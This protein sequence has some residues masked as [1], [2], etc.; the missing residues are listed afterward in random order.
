[1]TRAAR[2]WSIAAAFAALTAICALT[3]DEPIARALGV[4]EPSPLW[5]RGIAALEYAAG[6]EPW[7]WATLVVLGVGAAACLVRPAWRGALP[8]WIYVAG[9]GLLAAI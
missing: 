4:Y 8:A 5:N 2:L 1:M 9:T 6:I 7:R 3:I